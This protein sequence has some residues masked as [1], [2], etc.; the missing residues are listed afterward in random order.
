M[1]I[2]ESHRPASKDVTNSF[3]ALA[4]KR[5]VKAP[6]SN[7]SPELEHKGVGEGISVLKQSPWM[8]APANDVECDLFLSMGRHKTAKIGQQP[9]EDKSS[10]SFAFSTSSLTEQIRNQTKRPASPNTD[11]TQLPPDSDPKDT[12][13]LW[14]AVLALNRQL[15]MIPSFDG[16][17][18]ETSVPMTTRPGWFPPLEIDSCTRIL[19]VS[20]IFGASSGVA[21][22]G[23][24]MLAEHHV[25]NDHV[26]CFAKAAI[27]ARSP[28]YASLAELTDVAQRYLIR[29]TTSAPTEGILCARRIL[30]AQPD[31]QD[32]AA[33][34]WRV[35]RVRSNNWQQ[36]TGHDASQAAKD[37]HRKT[38]CVATTTPASFWLFLGNLRSDLRW[39]LIGSTGGFY[40]S[41]IAPYFSAHYCT[42]D[43][44]SH[45]S[46]EACDA[47]SIISGVGNTSLYN[48]YLLREEVAFAQETLPID[49]E[50]LAHYTVV[51]G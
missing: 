21:A 41:A 40:K 15:T 17:P 42:K 34:M 39:E 2:Y 22:A 33:S 12:H 30:G 49:M 27:R 28:G 24:P 16:A 35:P 18:E 19:P 45:R 1:H 38:W 50:G 36:Q 8:P 43:N 47:L 51:I 26:D 3:A 37:D 7:P 46:R 44:C 13:E 20:T 5:C 29:Y 11:P 10:S 14:R 4:Q 25:R 23:S 31:A 48:R 9:E 6:E 32:E